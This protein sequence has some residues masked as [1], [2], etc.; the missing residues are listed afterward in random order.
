MEDQ[1][2]QRHSSERRSVNTRNAVNGPGSANR[3]P[4]LPPGMSF[5]QRHRLRRRRDDENALADSLNTVQDAVDRL[6]EA[7][8]NLSSLLDE[9]IPRILTPNLV[10]DGYSG[11]A[12]VNRS[13]AKRRK[14][15]SGGMSPITK[16]G[17][18]G[19]VVPGLL[20]MRIESCDGGYIPD[21]PGAR[22]MRHYWPENI[23]QNNKSVY[24]TASGECNI[25][26]RHAGR[27]PFCLKKVVIK[28]PKAGFDAPVQEG[29]IFVS[30]AFEDLLK[31]TSHYHLR[32]RLP[33][34]PPLSRMPLDYR[35]PATVN[36]IPLYDD[37]FT[38]SGHAHLAQDS[39]HD[40]PP[41]RRAAYPSA[42][43]VPVS[44]SSN[45]AVGNRRDLHG[46]DNRANVIT[47]PVFPLI[48]LGDSSSPPPRTTSPTNAPLF[49][50]EMSCDDPSDDEE[51]ESSAGVLAD[52]AD[53][54][55][56]EYPPLT[57]S[58]S[59]DDEED[60]GHSRTLRRRI[61]TLRSAPRSIEWN[62]TMGP[63]TEVGGLKPKMLT[64]HAK[65]F[66]ERKSGTVS[67]KFDPPV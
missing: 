4:T 29:M 46:M 14:I 66:I 59:E 64:P 54:C 55:R 16:Y 26:Y 3:P 41:S 44:D 11:E 56:R 40:R 5:L 34:V 58:S 53:R 43:V 12:E 62:V 21:P 67:I 36:R 51:E 10:T 33:P 35:D 8:S 6:T 48:D 49:N 45:G 57:S 38:R 50:V 2:P 63:D 31:R 39:A 47:T 17:Y 60:G 7:S 18:R 15:D 28:A 25:V 1:T 19:S 23:L 61:R 30:M 20:Q 32:E 42:Q 9:P 27:A 22:M 65:F 24:C 37:I 52:L 13:R